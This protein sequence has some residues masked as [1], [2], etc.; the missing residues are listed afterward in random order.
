MHTRTYSVMHC[1][2]GHSARFFLNAVQC[3]KKNRTGTNLP[4]YSNYK[5]SFNFRS[6]VLPKTSFDKKALLILIIAHPA[7][8]SS[9]KL[10]E[11][12]TTEPQLLSGKDNLNTKCPETQFYTKFFRTQVLV[13]GLSPR[14]QCS[15]CL[16]KNRANTHHCRVIHD[17]I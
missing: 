9:T 12:D 5:Q 15:T 17:V 6:I 13:T 2:Y 4:P 14:H 1:D 16:P 3:K 10:D 7:S 11:F 8:Q